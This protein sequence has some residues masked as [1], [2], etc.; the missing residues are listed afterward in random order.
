[1]AGQDIPAC[2][3]GDF[4]AQGASIALPGF[5]LIAEISNSVELCLALSSST[6]SLDI[7]LPCVKATDSQ[8]QA[9]R[10]DAPQRQCPAVGS[11]GSTNR[12]AV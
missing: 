4:K 10:F 5:S 1:M 12:F 6:L 7:R 3:S 2:F 9:M 8:P 11:S